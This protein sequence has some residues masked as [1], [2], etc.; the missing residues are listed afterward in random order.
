MTTIT[1]K[2]NDKNKEAKALLAYLKKLS[3]VE[4]EEKEEGGYNPEFVKKV[5]DSHKNDKRITIEADKLWE[6]IP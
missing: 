5:M 3:Y 1:L 4:V 6:S 2:I